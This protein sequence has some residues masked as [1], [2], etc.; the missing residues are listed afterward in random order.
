MSDRY[1]KRPSWVGTASSLFLISCFSVS[2]RFFPASHRN[3]DHPNPHS[4]LLYTKKEARNQYDNEGEDIRKCGIHHSVCLLNKKASQI[5]GGRLFLVSAQ[6]R[7]RSPPNGKHLVKNKY[8]KNGDRREKFAGIHAFADFLIQVCI[9]TT[10]PHY[11]FKRRSLSR[12][13]QIRM[14][15]RPVCLRLPPLDIHALPASIL[16]PTP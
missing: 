12:A 8:E 13:P 10:P 14:I 2:L 7:L 3:R 4:L 5:L 1:I 11:N 6:L 16:T 15:N 9:S